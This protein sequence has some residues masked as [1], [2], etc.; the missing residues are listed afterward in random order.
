ML[1]L[2]LNEFCRVER[3]Q[4]LGALLWPDWHYGVLSMYGTHL[5][6]NHLVNGEKLDIQ[7]A[8]QLLDQSTTNK[9][10]DDIE[11]NNRLHLHCWHTD[12]QFSKFQFKANK[13]NHIQPH[14][15]INDTS[16]K[17]YVSEIKEAIVVV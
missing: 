16:P 11:K 8:D 17:G 3:E 14:T 4:K 12:E 2:S 13:Y 5:A 15:L 9:N 6:V 7:K 10:P 1:H